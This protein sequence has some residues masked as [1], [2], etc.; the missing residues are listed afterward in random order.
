MQAGAPDAVI[1]TYIDNHPGADRG[2]VAS[3]FLD[4]VNPQIEAIPDMSDRQQ[5]D[6]LVDLGFIPKGSKFYEAVTAEDIKNIQ[7]A[8]VEGWS[9]LTPREQKTILE[10]KPQDWSCAE[11]CKLRC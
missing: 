2:A 9:T 11:Q 8:S 6:K 3:R 4:R 5:F 10:L 7:V 1:Y